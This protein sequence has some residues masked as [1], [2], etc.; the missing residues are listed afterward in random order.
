MVASGRLSPPELMPRTSG[1]GGDQRSA[2][3]TGIDG[4]VGLDP[5][6]DLAAFPAA[7]LA[8]GGADRAERGAGPGVAGAA[9]GEHQMSGAER[10]GIAERCDRQLAGGDAQHGEVG[11]RIA[12][13]ELSRNAAPIGQGDADVL[14]AADGAVG[15]HDH[16]VAPVDSG[17]GQPGPGV[18]RDDRA[19]GARDGVGELVG[20]S[21]ECGRHGWFLRAEVRRKHRKARRPAVS[22]DRLGSWRIGRYENIRHGRGETVSEAPAPRSCSSSGGRACHCR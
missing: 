20:E 6:I 5:E 14:V 16:A 10:G 13:G 18:D 17:G 12:A 3:Q 1:V 8:A 15:G 22:A 4:E 2:A 9:E 11:A 19:R 21:G 7:P